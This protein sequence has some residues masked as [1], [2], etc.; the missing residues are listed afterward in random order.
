MFVRS[1]SIL[2]NGHDGRDQHEK[3]NDNCKSVGKVGQVQCSQ[4]RGDREPHQRNREQATPRQRRARENQPTHRKQD[5]EGIMERDPKKNGS[6]CCHPPG[7]TLCRCAG[8]CPSISCSTP[9][10]ALFS[11]PPN[12]HP[13]R[14]RT[15]NLSPIAGEEPNGDGGEKQVGNEGEERAHDR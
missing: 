11:G 5:Q 12:P 14:L 9:S 8:P 1:T 6:A 3:E 13:E 2:A 15:V 7:H 10:S 4:R